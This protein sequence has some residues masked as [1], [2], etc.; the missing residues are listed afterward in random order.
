MSYITLHEKRWIFLKLK[1]WLLR[2]KIVIHFSIAKHA[3]VDIHA[4]TNTLTCAGYALLG[5]KTPLLFYTH[6][7]PYYKYTCITTFCLEG[8][9]WMTTASPIDPTP[10]IIKTMYLQMPKW[11]KFGYICINFLNKTSAKYIL[12]GELNRSSCPKRHT[13]ITPKS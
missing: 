13:Y 2:S 7:H 5:S 10:C 9:G 6:M 3:C 8:R 4:H 11:L 12:I 1:N